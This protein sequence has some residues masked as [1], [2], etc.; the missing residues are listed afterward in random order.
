MVHA[1]DYDNDNDDEH[2]DDDDDDDDDDYDY[3]DGDDDDDEDEDDGLTP[4][5]TGVITEHK[6]NHHHI[7]VYFSY[8]KFVCISILFL[9]FI[10]LIELWPSNVYHIIR[11]GL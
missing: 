1:N 2:D 3:N 10:I 4:T 7:F 5:C 11:Q 9:G 6:S 8:P